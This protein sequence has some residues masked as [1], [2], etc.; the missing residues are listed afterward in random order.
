MYERKQGVTQRMETEQLALVQ[1]MK[2]QVKKMVQRC[3]DENQQAMD[4]LDIPK[5]SLLKKCSMQMHDMT[6]TAAHME[7]IKEEARYL[8]F[9][10]NVAYEYEK[11]SISIVSEMFENMNEN[12]SH[13]VEHMSAMIQNADNRGARLINGRTLYELDNKRTMLGKK[14]LSE[15]QIG[16]AGKEKINSFAQETAKQI[17]KIVA[18]TELK[19][20]I[21]AMLPF[22]ILLGIVLVSV[23]SGFFMN[24][25]DQE[26][27]SNGI[28]ISDAM[29]I[30]DWVKKLF[31]LQNVL[32]TLKIMGMS[33]VFI[34]VAIVLIVIVLYVVY[35]KL[36]KRSCNKKICK[37]SAAYL[38]KELLAFE[39]SGCMRQALDE[40]ISHAAKEYELHNATLLNDTFPFAE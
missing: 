2:Q 3:H 37:K 20:K 30:F 26:A 22:L 27:A 6:K 8:Q 33:A 25:A 31:G 18:G 11:G 35:V 12:Y 23:I 32:T 24:P 7:D 5:Q 4:E 9:Y 39:E 40:D 19:R 14:V 15:A 29:D 21:C 16:N 13:M 28:S 10:E 1:Q 17:R 38:E 36:L 34:V